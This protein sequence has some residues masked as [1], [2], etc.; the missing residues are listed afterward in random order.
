[1]RGNAARRWTEVPVGPGQ[2]AALRLLLLALPLVFSACGKPRQSVRPASPVARQPATPA[3]ASI[4]IGPPPPRG[5]EIVIAYSSN[6]FGE[7]EPCG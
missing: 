6:L 5:T 4:P 3:A 2:G 1:M 7:Y